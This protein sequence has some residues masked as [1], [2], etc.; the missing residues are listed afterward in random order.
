[1]GDKISALPAATSVDGTEIVPI[2]QAGTT[3]KVTGTL[4]RSPIGNAGGDLVGS[5]PN[6]TLAAITTAQSGVGSSTAIPVLS[7]DAKGRVTGLTTASN[8][9]GT[10]T[11]VTAGTGL[12]G[13][14]ITSNGTLS[15][16]YG[17]TAG[18][19][20]QGNDSR[21]S[22]IPI[23]GSTLPL[24]DSGAAVGTSTAFAR[25]DHVHPLG[26]VTL[27]G[28]VSGSGAGSISVSLA[29]ITSSQTNVGGLTQIPVISVDTKGRVT[30]LTTA[31]NPQTALTGL[32]GDVLANGPGT[33]GAS[34]SASGV[35]AGSY[36]YASTGMVPTFTVDEKGRIGSASESLIVLPSEKTST[37]SNNPQLASKTFVF[38]NVT[39]VLP[40]APRQWVTARVPGTNVWISGSVTG[41]TTSQVTISVLQSSD[42]TSVTQYT[43]WSL[44]LGQI[45][46]QAGA[47]P[48]A[49]QVLAY[50]T[51]GQW[52][53]V[54]PAGSSSNAT[55][56]QGYAI[57]ATGPTLNQSLQWDGTA[58]TPTT[59][60]SSDAASI[61]G[62]NVVAPSGEGPLYYSGGQFQVSAAG[63]VGGRLWDSAINYAIGD[64]V[65]T[66]EFEPIW[67][68]TTASINNVP[69]TTSAYWGPVKANAVQLASRDVSSNTPSDGEVLAWDDALQEWKPA[70]GGGGGSSDA[71]Q[72]QGEPIADQVPNALEVLTWAQISTGGGNYEWR[73]RPLGGNSI[74]T[75]GQGLVFNATAGWL[76]GDVNAV[77]LADIPVSTTDPTTNQALVYNGTEWAPAVVNAAQ[78]QGQ[79][80][81]S[82]APGTN[83]LLKFDGTNWVPFDGYAIPSWNAGTSYNTGDRV[84]YD[85]KIWVST[86][87]GSGQ[88]PSTGSTYWA[89][90]IG[91]NS[92]NPGNQSTPAYWLRITTPAGDGYMPIYV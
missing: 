81:S 71:T 38:T 16:A 51:N 64:V 87:A 9:Q 66:S 43:N 58:W 40:Y 22:T 46:N 69:S 1:M 32:T 31:A 65:T 41:V 84:W 7:V 76:A 28:D 72:L 11:S 60:G 35:V 17:T 36:G 50:N 19:A 13:G 3:K 21:F 53:P 2:V 52:T 61:R 20:T 57:S 86:T 25:A 23:A 47:A 63:S 70:A 91:S 75:E 39:S 82:S 24:A 14:T 56:L 62:A 48:T 83:N 26:T 10:V 59:G 78:L 8:P 4:L 80:V 15:V 89:E 68:C 30:S 54:T 79:S 88:T 45:I 29:N 34:L 33:V 67:I 18:T 92:G 55:S 12:S 90:N 49:G 27:S 5:Y 73:P 6:P 44:R 77:R 42:P 85:G 74:P 37:S